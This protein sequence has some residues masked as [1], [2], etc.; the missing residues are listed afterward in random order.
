MTYEQRLARR[1][2]INRRADAMGTIYVLIFGAVAVGSTISL[3]MK[4]FAAIF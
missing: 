2:Q 3:L 4:I 1:R